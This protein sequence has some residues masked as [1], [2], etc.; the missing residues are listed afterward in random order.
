MLAV[1]DVED[2]RDRL[3]RELVDDCPRCRGTG[4]LVS[5]AGGREPW[6]VPSEPCGCQ[7]E[8][9]RKCALLSGHVPREF[10][11]VEAL[12]FEWNR[13]QQGRIRAYCEDLAAAREGGRGWV[14]MGQNGVGKTALACSIL[15]A[16]VRVGFSAGY[17]TAQEYVGSAIAA[18]RDVDLETWRRSVAG[19]DFLVLDELGKEYRKEGSEFAI[20]ELDGLLRWRRGELLPTVICTNYTVGQLQGE[21]GASLWSIVLDRLDRLQFARG[22]FRV[23]LARAGGR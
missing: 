5:I 17:L 8:V 7:D 10:W 20:A 12:E 14:F 19:A 23:E 16:A 22:D 1:P 15:C 2:L 9:A 6:D 4:F 11:Q 3:T 13:E 21:Y 18:R